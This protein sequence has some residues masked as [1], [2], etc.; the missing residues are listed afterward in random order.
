MNW[1]VVKTS[2]E[3]NLGKQL[4]EVIGAVRTQE[5]IIGLIED[6]ELTYIDPDS[7]EVKVI[8]MDWGDLFEQ[9]RKIEIED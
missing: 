6:L 1:S 5:R 3:F 9:I 4:G 8:D 7:E 2:D